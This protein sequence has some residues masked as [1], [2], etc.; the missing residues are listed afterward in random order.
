[1]C[2][3]SVL[4]KFFRVELSV[5]ETNVHAKLNLTVSVKESQGAWTVREWGAGNNTAVSELSPS[6]GIWTT[7]IS[8]TKL[9]TKTDSACEMVER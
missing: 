8:G 9:E 5:Y 2:G 6:N 4:V 7:G 1:M 3:F